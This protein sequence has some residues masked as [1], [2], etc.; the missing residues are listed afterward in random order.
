[1]VKNKGT[2]DRA[3]HCTHKSVQSAILHTLQVDD[4]Y[5]SPLSVT[6]MAFHTSNTQT[7]TVMSVHWY[8]YTFGITRAVFHGHTRWLKEITEAL[9]NRL[10]DDTG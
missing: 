10:K 6:E 8:Y 9:I 7:R 2:G 1:M 3:R 5:C 4:V